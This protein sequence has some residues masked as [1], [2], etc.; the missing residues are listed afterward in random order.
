MKID[1]V[2]KMAKG[3]LKSFLEEEGGEW[4]TTKD[5]V[6]NWLSDKNFPFELDIDI[7]NKKIVIKLKD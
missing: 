6:N 4:S 7:S 3:K 2:L 1:F 5:K